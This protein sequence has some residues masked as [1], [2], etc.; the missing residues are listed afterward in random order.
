MGTKDEVLGLLEKHR[1]KNLSGEDI[2]C[3]LGI[4][5]TSVWKAVKS[6]ER[7]GHDIRAATN[8]GYQLSDG[9]NVLSIQGLL[10]YLSNENFAEK[11]RIY[12]SLESTNKT[13]KEMA[14]NGCEHGTVIIAD[15]QTAGRG[16]YGRSF[17]SPAG[18][19]LYM[20]FVL[21]SQFLDLPS[22]TMITA[23]AAVAVCRVIETAAGKKPAIKWVN[24]ILL[25]DKKICGILTEAVTDF[26]SG[27]IDWIVA[28]LGINVDTKDFPG[29]LSQSAASI[30]PDK[31]DGAVRNRLAAEI[32]N[33]FLSSGEWLNDGET[34]REY[35][36]RLTLLGRAITVMRAN[37]TFEAIALD[38]DETCRL[39]V[40]R[41]D[42][43]IAAL[44]SG[45]VS[46]KS[47]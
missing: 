44:S 35:K 22:P 27:G 30:F 46:V 16:R 19:G 23:A 26:E 14:V 32:V 36:D 15:E 1:G 5:R 38:V 4:S 29:D 9:N 41:Q 34:Y 11:I 40:K 12:K 21:R 10:P 37:E 42:G 20:S 6:L 8:R 13:A 17:Y 3:R 31:T 47:P 7:D 33:A 39:I 2:A 18:S 24:D 28:G 25:N 45:E 43:T